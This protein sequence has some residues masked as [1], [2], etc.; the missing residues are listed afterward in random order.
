M[1]LPNGYIR[2]YR[3]SSQKWSTQTQGY[4][5]EAHD[6]FNFDVG[7]LII[8]RTASLCCRQPLPKAEIMSLKPLPG[9]LGHFINREKCF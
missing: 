4:T 9:S 8:L 7:E 6:A 2:P 1:F 3:S 5:T